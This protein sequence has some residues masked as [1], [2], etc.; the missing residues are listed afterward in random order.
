MFRHEL[1]S[2]V[3]LMRALDCQH[4]DHADIHLTANDDE[5]LFQKVQQHRDEY[6]QEIT[7]D[8]I[9]E[10]VSTQAYDE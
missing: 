2:E 1:D 8:Q 3:R 4:P 10:L 9:R 5:E 6:H 7:D